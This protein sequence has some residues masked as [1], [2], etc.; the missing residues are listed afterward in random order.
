MGKFPS[1]ASGSISGRAAMLLVLGLLLGAASVPA[2]LSGTYTVGA[3]GDYATLTAAVAA[4]N[5]API[6]GPVL[7]TLL[8][9]SYPG[10]TIPIA[11]NA[12]AGASSTNALTI[13]PAA[14]VAVVIEGSPAA[15]G[16]I[17][18]NGADWV[19]IDG[20]NAGSSL[21]LR[22]TSASNGAIYLGSDATHNEI[23]NCTIEGGAI[24][25]VIRFDTPTATGND[26]NTFYS[27]VIRDRT[28]AAGVPQYLV[29][30]TASVGSPYSNS[31][32]LFLN[33]TFRNFT[34]NAIN[35]GNFAYTDSWQI[36]GNDFFQDA[37]RTGALSVIYFNALG[38]NNISDNT[39]HDMQTSSTGS[40]YGIQ[41]NASTTAAGAQVIS[42]NTIYNMTLTGTGGSLYGI[43][44]DGPGNVSTT[45][46]GNRIY[47]FG[48]T[49][50]S[51]TGTLYG[52]HNYGI[53]A[54]TKPLN[55]VNNM[56]TLAPTTNC[57][58][59]L[60]GI[61]LYGYTGNVENLYYNS[62]YLG[63]TAT[64]STATYA[65]VQRMG[66]TATATN[67]IA[68]NGRTGSTGTHYALAKYSTGTF[69]S[70]YN[71]CAGTGGT[72]A[73]NFFYS[74]SAGVNFATWQG[75]VRDLHSRAETAANVTTQHAMDFLDKSNAVGNLHVDP[76]ACLFVDN[77]GTPI[78]GYTTDYDLDT[79]D[80]SHPDIG[81]DEF[82]ALPRAPFDLNAD[83]TTD[84]LLRH[85]SS[86]ELTSWLMSGTGAA[87]GPYL[88]LVTG[89]DWQLTGVADFDDNGYADILWRQ[90][91]TGV[92]SVW[93][94]NAAGH[95]A[96]I[97]HGVIPT[98]WQIAAVADFDADRKA[99]LLLRNTTTHDCVIWYCADGGVVK[100]EKYLLTVDADWVVLGTGDLNLDGRDDIFWRKTSNG[101][102]S[103]WFVNE[104]GY[105]GNMSPGN[106]ASTV[107]VVGIGDADLDYKADLFL[108]DT[109][110]GDLTLWFCDETH[111][112][113]TAAFGV[114]GDTNWKPAGIGDYNLDFQSDL[115]W[116]NTSTG[117]LVVWY[118]DDTGYLG[119]FYVGNVAVAWKP[120]NDL[121]FGGRSLLSLLGVT[122][123][124][125]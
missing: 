54:S 61:D 86:Q 21:I 108:R 17:Y 53:S 22:S 64:G 52:I 42:N 88:D 77:T 5:A 73:A 57:N 14:G 9:T 115:L 62:V 25:G 116:Y 91:S 81:A 69:T 114:N 119:G 45:V 82:F 27:N 94:M 28:D 111:V 103:V 96:D 31:N 76:G 99:D 3:G 23:R 19:V 92:T 107:K 46:S 87:Q 12:N 71:A 49:N 44:I 55:I 100:F 112:K 95:Y 40:T 121:N 32:N 8:D 4:Y 93:K 117:D 113:G 43:R 123:I 58:C 33:N 110:T 15:N 63:G 13:R 39:I 89:T 41:F 120:Q 59:T 2:Q 124:W 30:S 68:F 37:A 98:G 106:L 105:I 104:N 122:P 60:R 97:S 75:G 56:I 80:V 36:T 20:L 24:N 48:P 1:R 85:D 10:E 125:Q 51:F 16:L 118:G 35:A 74:G 11:I 102:L 84:I 6:T 7:F 90:A 26:D 79:R 38:A 101:D 83:Y 70:D 78:V 29:Y 72:T 66:S 65:I 50:S 109:T 18:L 67:N 47:G 34:A